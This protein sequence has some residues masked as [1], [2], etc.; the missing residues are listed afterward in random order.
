MTFLETI[1]EELEAVEAEIQK[2]LA[3]VEAVVEE[4]AAPVEAVVEKHANP[5]IQ[6]ALDQAAERL[7][8]ETNQ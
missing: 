4:V 7:A 8:K 6:M 1:K 5:I 3:P 2:E